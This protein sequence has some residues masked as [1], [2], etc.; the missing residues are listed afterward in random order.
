MITRAHFDHTAAVTGSTYTPDH[1]ALRHKMATEWLPSGVDMKGFAHS[2]PGQL[3]RLST[4]DLNYVRRLLKS[5]P[6]MS[7]FVAPIVIPHEYRIQPIV[8]FR[9]QP[10]VQRRAILE[11]I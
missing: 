6:D 7:E 11:L 10:G 5:N 2:H 8:V 1:I 9:K 4:G 3:D